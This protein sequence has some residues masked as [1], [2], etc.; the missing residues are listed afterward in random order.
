TRWLEEGHV[1]ATPGSAFDAPG[2]IRLSYAA[3]MD[4]LKDAMER[5]RR[6]GGN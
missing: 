5:I 4:R 1:A 2:W 3:S 6:A